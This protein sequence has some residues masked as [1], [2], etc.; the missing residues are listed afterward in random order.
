MGINARNFRELVVRPTL[1]LMSMWSPEAERLLMLTA[2]QESH[3]GTYL[4]Q[5]WHT[6]DD[7]QGAAFGPFGMEAATL[8]WLRTKYPQWL[9]EREAYEMQWDLRL[10]V[11]A[12]RL[13]YCVVA[14]AI[15]A[16]DDIPGLASYWKR[17]YNT[18]AGAGTVEEAVANYNKYVRG[19]A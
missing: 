16:A 3:L 6:L 15:P 1:V 5:G 17:W 8:E 4:R 11:K 2:A 14:E 12:C 10:A 13:R 19:N 7:G 18:G 9:G